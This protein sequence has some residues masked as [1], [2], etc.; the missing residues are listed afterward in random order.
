MKKALFSC[1]FLLSCLTIWSQ[2]SKGN[3][4]NK[5]DTVFLEKLMQSK[6]AFFKHILA[7]PDSFQVQIVYTQINRDAKNKPS[8]KEY[9]FHLGKQYFYPAS[10]VKMP[11]AFL[12]LEKLKDLDIKGLDRNTTMVTDSAY[13]GQTMV[14]NQP[15]A[16]DGRA[17][18]ENYIKQI[19]LV[20]DN[21]AFN[22]LYEFVGQETIQEKLT[23]KGYPEMVIRHRLD[24]S[25][26]A[27]QNRA[28]N[29]IVFYDTASQK[30]YQQA[31]TFSKA[32]FPKKTIQMGKGFYKNGQLINTAFDF[33]EKNSVPLIDQHHIIQSVL[34][35]EYVE[36]KR[37]F[38]WQTGVDSFVL[39]WMSAY[40]KE[41]SFPN[42]DSSHYWDAY[43]KFLLYGSEKGS[44]P[45]GIRIFNKVGDAYGFLTDIAY[46]VD[47]DNK[48]EFLLSATI[49]CNSDGI[50]N[51]DKYDYDRIGYPFLKN[52]GQLILDYEKTR[53]RRFVP[54]LSKFQFIR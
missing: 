54:D 19:F 5:R 33:S 11:I 40:P 42:Y 4:S 26:T 43:C 50:Y 32:D 48:V 24:V 39:R 34:F 18:I 51:D 52:L 22:R 9:S 20:S 21:D 3:A 2:T 16:I 10:T 12:A 14:Y 31:G 25:M 23:V 1:L 27:D 47:F 17:T 38:N 15:N 44:L 13:S 29:P 6:P 35:P 8:F 36:K 49:S 7:Y 41:S 37:R 30:I 53:E 46:I 28:G 45:S